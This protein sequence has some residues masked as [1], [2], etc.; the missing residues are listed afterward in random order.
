MAGILATDRSIAQEASG[1]CRDLA[2]SF[3]VVIKP[4]GAGLNRDTMDMLEAETSDCK[5]AELAA[6]SAWGPQKSGEQAD[7]IQLVGKLLEK[8]ARPRGV[9]PLTPRSVVWCSI[10]LSYG[11]VRR[12]EP[13]VVARITTPAGPDQARRIGRTRTNPPQGSQAARGAAK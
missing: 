13:A 8:L 12:S 7:K 11:R 6:G 9:E 4:P 2:R 5:A 3:T 10:Q 1:V